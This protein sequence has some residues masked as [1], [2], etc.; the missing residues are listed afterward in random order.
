MASRAHSSTAATIASVVSAASGSWW[1]NG[2][3]ASSSARPAKRARTKPGALLM[4]PA[5]L[6][7]ELH[8]QRRG[9][10]APAALAL[11]LEPLL[12][13]GQALDDLRRSARVHVAQDAASKRSEARAEH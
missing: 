10:V 3:S 7:G 5:A 12:E 6:L 2:T 4:E 11:G 8:Q 1:G 13:R 9:L